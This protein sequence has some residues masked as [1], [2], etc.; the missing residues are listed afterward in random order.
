MFEDHYQHLF[1]TQQVIN[2]WHLILAEEVYRLHTLLVL[3][4]LEFLGL[5]TSWKSLLDKVRYSKF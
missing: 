2:C 3:E 1:E 5:G 4:I